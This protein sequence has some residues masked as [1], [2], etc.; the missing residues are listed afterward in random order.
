MRFRLWTS[1]LRF[2]LAGSLLLIGSVASA[3]PK[4]DVGAAT[5]KWAQTLGARCHSLL[6]AEVPASLGHYDAWGKPW[7]RKRWVKSPWAAGGEAAHDSR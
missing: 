3:G 5:M 4:E 2:V 1:A 6:V 7:S